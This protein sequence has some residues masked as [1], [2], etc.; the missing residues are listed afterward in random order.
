MLSH[1][2][3]LKV[4]ENFRV[5]ETLYPGRIVLGISRAPGAD[6]IA[7][8][9]LANGGNPLSV[10]DFPRKVSDLLGY[11]GDGL[12]PGHPFESLRAM[13]DGET[14]PVTWLLGSSDQ[15]A[16][17]VA[18]FGCPFSFAHFINNRGAA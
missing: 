17:L 7:S 5:L 1:Y 12:E 3:P 14:Q 2:S 9:A 13:P 11:L 4:A 16:I 15:S 10:E 18:H 6:L 8:R